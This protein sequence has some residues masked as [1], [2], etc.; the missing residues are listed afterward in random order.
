M[1]GL[2][3]GALPWVDRAVVTL[4]RQDGEVVFQGRG[5]DLKLAGTRTGSSP[6][7]AY[8][9]VRM[10]GSAYAA[11][12]DMAVTAEVDYSLSV[13]QPRP[14]VEIA[15]LDARAHLPGFGQCTT[16][17]DSD[18]D[19]VEL[20]CLQAGEAPS[21]ITATLA[22]P[23]TGRRNPETRICAPNYSPY[24]P[25]L[26]PDAIRRF[27]VEAPFR[28]RLRLGDYPVGGAQLGRAMLVLTRYDASQHV[29]GRMTANP[30]RLASWAPQGG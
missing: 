11:L 19:D 18:G 24:D 6:A 15:A 13:L 8:E 30:V 10:H 2:P 25:Q 28:D 21:C 14:P 16:D 17:R 22:D 1:G 4:R 12:K 27:Q 9:A 29:S 23:A 3:A 20:Q 7:L 26:F 5:D